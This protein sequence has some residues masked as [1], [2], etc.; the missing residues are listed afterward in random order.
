MS[1]QRNLATGP[2]ALEIKSLEGNVHPEPMVIPVYEVAPLGCQVMDAIGQLVSALHCY[3]VARQPVEG[4]G[5]S[6]KDD[7]H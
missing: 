5:C 3:R 4:I 7:K 2:N 6:L 1:P